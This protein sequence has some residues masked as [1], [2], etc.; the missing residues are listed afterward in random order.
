MLS[1]TGSLVQLF[2]WDLKSLWLT[3]HQK[4]CQAFL[5]SRKANEA[6]E[7]YT[8]M[9]NN[10]DETTKASCLDWSTGKSL[11]ECSAL[12]AVNGDA[13]LTASDEAKVGGNY[14]GRMR[15]STRQKV[16]KLNPSSYVGHQL[17]HAALRGAQRYDE[18]I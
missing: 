10:I 2:G 17:T 1:I 3:T 6:L 18:A 13:A 7:S 15:F 5:S 14:Y 8:S 9:M 11:K 4:R 12:Y 16:T